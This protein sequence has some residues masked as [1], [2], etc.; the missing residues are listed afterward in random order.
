MPGTQRR[1]FGSDGACGGLAA[2]S[3]RIVSV[4]TVWAFIAVAFSSLVFDRLG[5]GTRVR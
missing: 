3:A 1:R 2:L 5:R 4:Y